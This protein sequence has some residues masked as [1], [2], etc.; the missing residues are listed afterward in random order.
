[1]NE[2]ASAI[3]HD[4]DT[5]FA[6]SKLEAWKL[7]Y[8]LDNDTD[9]FTWAANSEDPIKI[10]TDDELWFAAKGT[11]DIDGITYHLWY[12]SEFQPDEGTPGYLAT[13]S[14]LPGV[15]DGCATVNLDDEIVIEEGY[16][17]V[18]QI[19]SPSATNGTGVIYRMVDEY[20]NDYPYDFKN[21]Q[22]KRYKCTKDTKSVF[23]GEYIG[24]KDAA[25]MYP[26]D[27]SRFTFDE[28]D[29]QWCY[30]FN[31]SSTTAYRDASLSGSD[32]N[33][34]MPQV[35]SLPN[36]VMGTNCYG[37]T[38]GNS[39]YSWTT[40][41]SCHSWTTGNSCRSWTTGNYCYSWTTGNYC[42]SWTTGNSSGTSAVPQNY[43]QCFHLASGVQ[44]V[45]ISTD[46]TV[47]SAVPFKN[48]VVKSGVKGTSSSRL[49]IVVDSSKFPNNSDYEWII[50]KN[51][52]GEIKQ[53]CEADLIQ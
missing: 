33:N 23:T 8:C 24:C 34:K 48:F 26:T 44:Y 7:N 25:A 3:Q 53:Y 45:A 41:N 1:M 28:T 2:E 14:E 22:Y 18:K 27:E 40:G 51:S 15:N 17:Y 13:T 35:T 12:N 36:C 47:S 5:Y 50:A 16:S 4:G 43:V 38:T 11:I 29:F 9:R 49:S 39:C 21:I 32:Y 46:G 6:N 10:Y 19:K 31:D 52:S 42:Y 30:T 37:T 20:D